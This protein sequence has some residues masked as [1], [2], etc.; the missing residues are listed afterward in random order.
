MSV[1]ATAS[2]RPVASNATRHA[3]RSRA[4]AAAGRPR[5][6]AQGTR[7]FTVFWWRHRRVVHRYVAVCGPGDTILVP[8]DWF[9][10][11]VALTPSI[12]R[13]RRPLPLTATDGH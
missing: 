2:N 13:A 7:A 6:C 1:V 9:H 12:V 5:L 3:E 10:Y 11:A 8:S 4:R